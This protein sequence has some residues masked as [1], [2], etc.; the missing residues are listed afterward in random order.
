MHNGENLLFRK[1]V[2]DPIELPVLLHRNWFEELKRLVPT[3]R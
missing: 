2:G 1:R 3:G